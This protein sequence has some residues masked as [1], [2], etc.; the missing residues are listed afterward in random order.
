MPTDCDTDSHLCNLRGTV[1]RVMNGYGFIT[2][3]QPRRSV[4]VHRSTILNPRPNDMKNLGLKE[5]DRVILDAEVSPENFKV[6]Y[7]AIRV[8][9]LESENE[10]AASTMSVSM[11]CAD[12]NVKLENKVGTICCV[13]RDG[14]SLKFGPR[15]VLCAVFDRSC[16]PGTLLKPSEKVSDIFSVGD[17]VCFHAR[18]IKNCTEF[19]VTSV[20][21][22]RREESSEVFV[23]DTVPTG[24][25]VSNVKKE[26]TCTSYRGNAD[27]CSNWRGIATA[28]ECSSVNKG[29]ANQLIFV[30][31]TS[32]P[33]VPF[34]NPWSTFENGA[35]AMHSAWPQLSNDPKLPASAN[36]L[37]GPI[38][39]NSSK[40]S[41][42]FHTD[43][44]PTMSVPAV[45]NSDTEKREAL[46]AELNLVDC[47][48]KISTMEHSAPASQGNGTKNKPIFLPPSCNNP[49]E[50][51]KC[52]LDDG[53]SSK[54]SW[55]HNVPVPT[56]HHPAPASTD[57]PPRYT[58]TSE[59]TAGQGFHFDTT[60]VSNGEKQWVT[61]AS[62]GLPTTAADER[63]AAVA[64][65]TKGNASNKHDAVA[66]EKLGLDSGCVSHNSS[67]SSGPP[68]WTS[69][70]TSLSSPGCR[71]SVHSNAKAVVERV[72]ERSARVRFELEGI[73][74][75][76]D[77]MAICLYRDG[78]NITGDLRCALSEGD[79]IMLDY[80]I[81]S[82]GCELLIH[83]NAAWQGQKPQGVPYATPEEFLEMLYAYRASDEGSLPSADWRSSDRNC[84]SVKS[85]KT[86]VDRE[87]LPLQA[88][89][90]PGTAAGVCHE[91]R[92]ALDE[93]TLQRLAT[94]MKKAVQ[95]QIHQV[96][97]RVKLESLRRFGIPEEAIGVS[98]HNGPSVESY[99]TIVDPEQLPLQVAEA[100]GTAAGAGHEDEEAL[101]K[102][103]MD[104][105]STQLWKE[106]PKVIHS[107][108]Q[109][110]RLKFLVQW[111]IATENYSG[112]Y[113]G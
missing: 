51:P 78:R 77:V 54:E 11:P 72:Q 58:I 41:Q 65:P 48:R 113:S 88:A 42:V 83:C 61:R 76:I 102:E 17:K 47:G 93:V 91:D 38:I 16:I 63:Q 80:M 104:R 3:E 87:Q 57:R 85:Y 6:R 35:S 30:P 13:S 2:V 22:V 43:V 111:G 5:N 21:T 74:N 4:F 26:V 55:E 28:N 73:S 106:I 101:E 12:S 20:T 27:E 90:A 8:R 92:Q 9:R 32:D 59:R 98:D 64:V 53:H 108:L 60:F 1:S 45:K 24:Y 46:P 67:N 109:A 81:G 40:Y 52:T 36:V 49:P 62:D 50:K 110:I 23:Y 71:V 68:P 97:Q 31:F 84:P 18:A 29:L 10:A 96:M 7:Q 19:Q 107:V 112:Y 14:G 70:E 69:T 34:Q 99:K 25:A 44:A 37:P 15:D 86:M 75:S 82:T 89:E 66:L 95:G 100:P 79:E 33:R 56:S 105:V 94:H 103:I 39:A